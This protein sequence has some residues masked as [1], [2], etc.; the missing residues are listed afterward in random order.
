MEE[1]DEYLIGEYLEGNQE[2]LKLLIDRY[3]PSIYNFV[4]RFV[5]ADNS[6]DIV[7]DVFVKVWKNIKKFDAK[8]A[9]F[10]TW[11]FKITRNTVTDYLRK[12]KNLP[13]SSLDTEEESFE[14]GIKDEEILPD[15]ALLKLEDKELLN[16]LLN[17][18]PVYYREV[19]ILYYQE[20]MTFSEIGTLL[21]K[22]LNTVKS[23]HR[24]ALIK[25]REMI[26]PKM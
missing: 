11:I 1:N 17:E 26:A 6:P 8:R 16:K 15:A 10:K 14:A 23:Y 12:K 13:F 18:I 20:D 21:D 5:G 4:A 2:T 7:Q 3:T 19:L 25:L 24:R 9:S 22:P